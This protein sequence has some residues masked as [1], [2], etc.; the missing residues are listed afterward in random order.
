MST[1]KLLFQPA[2]GACRSPP[3][4]ALPTPSGA[5]VSEMSKKSPLIAAT[6]PACLAIHSTEVPEATFSVATRSKVLAGL[7]MSTVSSWKRTVL[8]MLAPR[9]SSWS[10]VRYSMPGAIVQAVSESTVAGARRAVGGSGS[11][12]H[13][14]LPSLVC[15]GRSSVPVP[16]ARSPV[17]RW[18]SAAWQPGDGAPVAPVPV[19]ALGGGSRDGQGQSAGADGEAGHG[20]PDGPSSR[21]RASCRRSHALQGRGRRH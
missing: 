20:Q 2:A 17:A 4:R 10:Q 21:Q 1:Q 15:W 5:P 19:G 7:T 16:G 14:A 6:A 9:G 8:G 13:P 12:T 11:A 18:A 3:F